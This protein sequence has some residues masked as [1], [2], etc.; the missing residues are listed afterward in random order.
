MRCR[1]ILGGAAIVGLLLLPGGARAAQGP[2]RYFVIE[3]VDKDTGRG[4][5][6]VELKTV[7]EVRYVTDSAGLVAFHE[8]GLMDRDVFFHVSSHGY[9]FPKDGF[10]YRGTRLRTTPGGTARLAV[11]RLNIAER[12]YRVTGQ[13]IYRDSVLAGRRPPTHDPVLSGGVLGQDSVFGVPYRGK[14]Y[15]FWGDTN[16]ASYP[17]GQFATSG[18]TSEL[19]DRGGLDPAVGVDLTYVV[20][21]EGFSRKMAPLPKAGMVWLDG[22]VTVADES[23]RE[24]LV[25]H[26]SLMK[27][28]SERLEHGLMVYNDEKEVFEPLVRLA[29]DV[30]LHPEGQATR[31]TVGDQAYSYFAQPYPFVRVK[32]DWKS[33]LDPAAYEAFTC[34]AAG[35]G[36]D[37]NAPALDRDAAGRLVWGWKRD[38]AAVNVDRHHELVAAGKIASGEVWMDLR[39]AQGGKPVRAHRGS[40]RWNAYR[41]RWIMIF[42]QFWGTSALGEIWYAEADAPEGPWRTARKIVTHDTYSFY[43][44]VHHP[45]FD[46]QGGRIIYFEGTYTQAFSG[47]T[48]PTPRYDYNQIMYRLDLSAPRLALP[49]SPPGGKGS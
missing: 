33:L 21:A 16:R 48:V 32:A 31:V 35:S 24:R 14:L 10:G 1:W 49:A 38:T 27:S 19:P 3:V 40:V 43:N 30:R 11:Q 29:D 25:A 44:P 23:G 4:V 41:G 17:L 15:W 6:L 22:L 18:A 39:D 47:A 28:L 12:L 45:F 36:F 20:D 37:K 34:L 46:Q 2:E 9:E 7:N 5:P 8:P 42:C 13:G 26:Y